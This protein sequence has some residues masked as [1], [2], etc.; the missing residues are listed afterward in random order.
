MKVVG[1]IVNES[2]WDSFSLDIG[3][4]TILSV[5]NHKGNLVFWTAGEPDPEIVRTRQFVAIRTRDEIPCSYKDSPYYGNS[6]YIG[7]VQFENG[8]KVRHI[9]EILV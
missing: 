8:D 5:Q 4:C 9:F 3:G 1:H 2:S 6:V 7:T